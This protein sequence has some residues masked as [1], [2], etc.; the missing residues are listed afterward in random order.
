[1][2][3]FFIQIHSFF[4]HCGIV[5]VKNNK[6]YILENTRKDDYE[7]HEYKGYQRKCIC[8]KNKKY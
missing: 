4:S 3:D 5:V 2:E 8:Y 1:M 6:K 7:S